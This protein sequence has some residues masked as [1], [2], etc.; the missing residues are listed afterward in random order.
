MVMKVRK[1]IQQRSR[2]DSTLYQFPREGD[3]RIYIFYSHHITPLFYNS[4]TIRENRIKQSQNSETI[5]SYCQDCCRKQSSTVESG[6]TIIRNW[7]IA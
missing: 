5:M 6:P 7:K 3:Y 1:P 2:I 4:Q